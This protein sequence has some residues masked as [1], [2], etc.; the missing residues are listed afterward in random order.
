MPLCRRWFY[1]SEMAITNRHGGGLTLQRVLGTDLDA[2]AGFVHVHPFASREPIVDTLASRAIDLHVLDPVRRPRP[3]SIGDYVER[4]ARRL[5]LDHVVPDHARRRHA[6]WAALLARQLPLDASAWLVVPQGTAAIAVMNRLHRRSGA[7][8]VAWMMDDHLVEWADGWRYPRGFEGALA[9]HL[10]HAA[11][12]F[13]ISDAMGDLYRER[14]GVESQVLFGPAADMGDP[15]PEPPRGSGPLR[16][17]YFGALRRWQRDGLERLAARL[18]A[19]DATL[20]LYTFGEPGPWLTAARIE[21]RDPLPAPQ[22]RGRMCDYDA[23][24]TPISFDPETRGLA[25]LNMATKLSECLASGTATLV[26][27]PEY[28]AMVRFVREHGGAI[29]ITD[30]DDPR[31]H[32]QVRALREPAVR[33]PLLARARELALGMCS[34]GGMHQRWAA[35]RDRV[36]AR[37]P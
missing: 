34:Q 24:I 28:A 13:V 33:G 3:D 16:L 36:D 17:G 10:R 19:L 23:V 37:H 35:A 6:G 2:F 26:V 18:E 32:A 14:F 22:V 11:A 4:V 1:L 25:A 12:V 27:G 20:D 29:A 7:P 5:H 21:R 15:V 31:Q 8:Y 30:L 9:R